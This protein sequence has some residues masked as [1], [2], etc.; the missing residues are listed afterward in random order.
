MNLTGEKGEET[1]KSGTIGSVVK[2][3]YKE[4]LVRGYGT[5]FQ[6]L[7]FFVSEFTRERYLNFY[8][9]R[10]DGQFPD[11]YLSGVRKTSLVWRVY[12]PGLQIY[13]HIYKPKFLWVS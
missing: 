1:I 13:N 10:S 8:S 6:S 4:Q 3:T 7:I 12:N 2:L 11:P 5:Y 9:S